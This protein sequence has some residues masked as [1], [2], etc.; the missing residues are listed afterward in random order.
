MDAHIGAGFVYA[1]STACLAT[2]AVAQPIFDFERAEIQAFDAGAFALGFDFECFFYAKPVFPSDVFGG[3]V[4][5]VFVAIGGLGELQ[6]HAAGGARIEVDAV[7]MFHAA[8]RGY[9]AIGG[10]NLGAVL[11]GKLLRENGF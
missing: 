10:D 4:K 11:L 1:G 7:N 5:V 6:Q 8:M 9:A 3:A 2:E